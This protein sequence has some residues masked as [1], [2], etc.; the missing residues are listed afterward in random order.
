MSSGILRILCDEEVKNDRGGRSRGL[1][2][3][4][5][6]GL[7]ESRWNV[8]CNHLQLKVRKVEFCIKVFLTNWGWAPCPC[9]VSVC[10]WQRGCMLSVG[11]GKFAIEYDLKFNSG[12]SASSRIGCNI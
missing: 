1:N 12:K 7:L 9:P 3:V 11:Y 4:H 6:V 2:L 10:H 8:K 5:S